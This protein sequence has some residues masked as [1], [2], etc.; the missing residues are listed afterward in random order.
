M[1]EKK[2]ISEKPTRIR[3]PISYIS[4]FEKN[5]VTFWSNDSYLIEGAKV[6]VTSLRHIDQIHGSSCAHQICPNSF[7]EKNVLKLEGT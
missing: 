2:S 4:N 7:Y 5:F 1:I 6:K 3:Y